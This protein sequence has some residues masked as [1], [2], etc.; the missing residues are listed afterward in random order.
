MIY[1]QQYWWIY[2]IMIF[3]TWG[4]LIWIASLSYSS[5]G[6]GAFVLFGGL[7]WPVAFLILLLV[8]LILGI[9][10]LAN[11]IRQRR[12]AHDAKKEQSNDKTKH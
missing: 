4:V 8:I 11:A 1:V 6:D 10:D 9:V 7:I 5:T 12:A 3:L 2:T